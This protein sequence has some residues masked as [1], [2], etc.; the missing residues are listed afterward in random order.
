MNR[1]DI[2]IRR[3]EQIVQKSA[4]DAL[5]GPDFE[6]FVWVDTELR[7]VLD[8]Y[9]AMPSFHTEAVWPLWALKSDADTVERKLVDRISAAIRDCAKALL[10]L[11][12][13]PLV[14]RKL[15]AVDD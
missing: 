8:E 1:L 7:G 13:K 4:L 15:E 3:Y 2:A 11:A 14:N 6:L 12:Q 9:V 10:Q 5:D